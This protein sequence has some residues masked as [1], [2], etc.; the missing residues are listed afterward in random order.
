MLLLRVASS[1]RLNAAFFN[2]VHKQR[3][4]Y[5]DLPTL[6]HIK[7]CWYWD[8]R[9]LAHTPSQSEGLDPATD[10]RFI[11]DAGTRPGMHYDTLATRIVYFHRFYMF[12]SFKQFPRYVKLPN[13][14]PPPPNPPPPDPVNPDHK[15]S[16]SYPPAPDLPSKPTPAP[17]P[18]CSRPPP[19]PPMDLP[20]SSSLVSNNGYQKLQSTMKTEGSCYT[21]LPQACAL[22]LGYHPYPPGPTSYYT[23]PVSAYSYL[24]APPHPSVMGMAPNLSSGYP[25]PSTAGHNQLLLLLPECRI[26]IRIGAKKT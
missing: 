20:S 6:E 23:A 13:I 17:L 18:L 24:L 4:G 16:S 15:L 5:K 7:P 26:C 3:R 12:H 2:T 8:K 9:D 10:A 11:F 1:G 22:P 14:E 21:T 25:L 19:R